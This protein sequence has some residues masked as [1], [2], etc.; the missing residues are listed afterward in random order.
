MPRNAKSFRAGVHVSDWSPLLSII[1]SG[2]ESPVTGPVLAVT[3]M[4]V[5][6]AQVRTLAHVPRP[7]VSSHLRTS[8]FGIS[9]CETPDAQEFSRSKTGGQSRHAYFRSGGGQNPFRRQ[10]R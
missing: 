10:S 8:G 2:S 9:G 6:N 1:E 3:G 5:G 4:M 7:A